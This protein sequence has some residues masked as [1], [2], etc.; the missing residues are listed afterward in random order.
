MKKTC[1]ILG[2]LVSGMQ[3]AYAEESTAEDASQ[4]EV[5]AAPSVFE[6]CKAIGERNVCYLE[7]VG[8]EGKSTFLASEE[9]MLVLGLD[10][11]KVQELGIDLVVVAA[12]DYDDARSGS[13]ARRVDYFDANPKFHTLS[14]KCSLGVAGSIGTVGLGGA[15][16]GP[17]GVAIGGLSGLAIGVATFCM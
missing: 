4:V 12:E 13:N 2:L 9:N 10:Q 16:F 8:A 14:W 6:H 1:L 3:V 17:L 11:E 5:D 7:K 15:A